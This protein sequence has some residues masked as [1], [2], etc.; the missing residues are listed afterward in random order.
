LW[1]LSSCLNQSQQD[2]FPQED[3]G[4]L[5][6]TYELPEASSTNRSLVTLDSMMKIVQ[7]TPGIAHYAALG[8]L[9]V[10]TFATKSNSGTIFTQLKP[11][12][13]RK[14]KDKQLSG[15]IAILQQKFASLKEA[16]IV[17][18]P[19]PAIPGTWPNRRFYF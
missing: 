7:S 4:R 15:I 18:I 1:A 19:P 11:W 3:E 9:N 12:S 8:G 16:N 5:F 13:E 6:I 2:L 14:D 17:V 10:V